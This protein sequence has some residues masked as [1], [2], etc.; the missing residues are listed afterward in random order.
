MSFRKSVFDPLVTVSQIALVQSTFYL[1]T[2]VLFM[3]MDVLFGFPSTLSQILDWSLV[4]SYTT[5]GWILFTVGLINS[6]INTI[7][8]L[9]V[10]KRAKKCLDFACTT[11]FLHL[12]IAWLYTGLFP[13]SIFYWIYL[14]S[15]T[16]ILSA[17]SEYL[18]MNQELEPIVIG[19][20]ETY[21]VE[22]MRLDPESK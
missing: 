5:F 4:N 19:K 1:S 22:M 2:G 20:R 3:F 16:S 13:N 17:G 7:T 12:V 11:Y 21:D 18:C 14:V 10:V 9:L 15:C 6:S 8:I